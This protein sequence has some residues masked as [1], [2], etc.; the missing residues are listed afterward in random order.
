MQV[1]L[2]GGAVRDR[3]LGLP[4][5][6]RDYVVTGATPEQ[7]TA[8]GYKPVGRDFPVFLHPQTHAEYALA[9]TER[10]H[11]RGHQGFVF[12]TGAEISIE[13]DLIRRDLTINAIAEDSDGRLI[14]PYHGRADLE[15][16]ILRH[17]SPAFA[18]DPLRVLRVARFA[19]RLAPFGFQIAAETMALMRQISTS[20]ELQTLSVERIWQELHKAMISPAP[21][22]CIEVLRD[23]GALAQLL[24]EVDALFGVPQVAEY[25]PEID[26]GEHVLLTLQLAAEQGCATEIIFALLLHDLGKALTPPQ[27]LPRHHGHEHSGVP[28]IR[29][30]CARL[31]VPKKYTELALLVGRWHLLVHQ[32]LELRPATLLQLLECCDAMRRPQRFEQIL[33]ACEIDKRGRKGLQDRAYP[34]R[35][36][37]LAALESVKSVNFASI[38]NASGSGKVKKEIFRSLK[39]EKLRIFHRFHHKRGQLDD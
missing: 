15:Q 3:L 4:G 24:P 2:V 34:Q 5:S 26:T 14:D 39:L 17:V 23:C 25:H 19:A 10:K 18:E 36:Y 38:D 11:G 6:D 31:K 28:L 30:V 37:L 29:D 7:M 27:Q 12:H 9:R 35:A 1:Y 33:L 13:D 32:A 21:Q 22:R 20:G 16:R 8:L